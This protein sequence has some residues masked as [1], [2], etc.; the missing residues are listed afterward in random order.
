MKTTRQR[1]LGCR[2]VNHQSVWWPQGHGKRRMTVM[3]IGWHSEKICKH[4]RK[5]NMSAPNRKRVLRK[6]KRSESV[7]ALDFALIRFFVQ[8]MKTRKSLFLCQRSHYWRSSGA[9]KNRTLIQCQWLF[10]LVNSW[11]NALPDLLNFSGSNANDD[12][13][14]LTRDLFFPQKPVACRCTD[15]QQKINLCHCPNLWPFSNSLSNRVSCI[16]TTDLP[17]TLLRCPFFLVHQG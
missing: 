5:W 9:R 8:I 7:T 14:T 13:L 16:L 2:L 12:Y 17:K 10:G 4:R 1:V 6:T 15:A 3:R 11:R